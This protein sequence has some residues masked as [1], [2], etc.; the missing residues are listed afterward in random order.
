MTFYLDLFEEIAS[1]LLTLSNRQRQTIGRTNANE[2]IR[3]GE[4]RD[5]WF[6]VDDASRIPPFQVPPWK[7]LKC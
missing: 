1:Q 3:L 6:V 7:C 5:G 2:C 4:E